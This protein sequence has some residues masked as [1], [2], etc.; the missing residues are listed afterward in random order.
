MPAPGFCPRRGRGPHPPPGG[1][2]EKPSP[3]DVELRNGLEAADEV[4]GFDLDAEDGAFRRPGE[5]GKIGVF[6][7]V[8]TS[9]SIH[10]TKLYETYQ[11][12]F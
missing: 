1:L 12:E 7:N 8:I 3:A 5:G 9:Y 6:P 4:V 11:K 2:A 10:Y